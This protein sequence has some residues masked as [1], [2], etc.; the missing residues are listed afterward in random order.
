MYLLE[1]WGQGVESP[2]ELVE[3]PGVDPARELAAN[4]RRVDVSGQQKPGLENRLAVHDF[5]E[6]LESHGSNVARMASCCTELPYGWPAYPYRGSQYAYRGSRYPYRRLPMLT[7]E[8][9]IDTA[10]QGIDTFGLPSATAGAP[11]SFSFA[12]SFLIAPALC[13]T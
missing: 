8:R 10:D 1:R 12:I 5:E 4:V 3:A 11:Y 13:M 7:G 2:P 6:I 9:G